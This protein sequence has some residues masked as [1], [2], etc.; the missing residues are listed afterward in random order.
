[1]II[2]ATAAEDWETVREGAAKVGMPLQ[3]TEGPIEEEMGLVR[4]I[5]PA[6]DG[7]QRQVI[8]LRTGPA[9]ARLAIPQPPGM[10]Y[11]AG[12]LVVFDPQLLEPIPESPE[13]QENFVPPFAAVSML[14]PGGYTSWFFDGAAPSEADW[15]EFNEVL[16]ER[17][18]PMWVYSDDNY[19]VTHPTSGEPLPGVFGWIAVPPDGQPGRGRRAARRR[20]RAVG[21]P[22]GL[23]RPGQGRRRRGGAARAHHQGVRPVDPGRG[24]RTRRSG[25]SVVF[26]PPGSLGA[27]RIRKQDTARGGPPLTGG[28]LLQVAGGE[29]AAPEQT[30]GQ[31]GEPH[32][33][34]VEPAGVFG[35]EGDPEAG[36]SRQPGA[37]GAWRCDWTRYP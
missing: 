3:S 34:H 8:S 30:S 24:C 36:M 26:S 29:L 16:A 11:N 37:G 21:A 31:H 17:G 19:T 22:A 12:D 28:V 10:D 35:G 27:A 18:W 1:M 5:L 4:V 20:H 33:D 6:P 23:A 7:S 32:F 2:M 9:T 15:T 14:R 13:E 25:P